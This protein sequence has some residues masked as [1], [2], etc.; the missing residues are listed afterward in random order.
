MKKVGIDKI[1][2]VGRDYHGKYEDDYCYFTYWNEAE[3]KFEKDAKRAHIKKANQ[4]EIED[5]D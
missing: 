3:K 1:F 2:F 5:K 4:C